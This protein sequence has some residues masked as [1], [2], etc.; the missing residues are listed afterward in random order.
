MQNS[1]RLV[2]IPPNL[3][4]S[5]SYKDLRRALLRV[6][7]DAPAAQLLITA[8][9][10]LIRVE[11]QYLACQHELDLVSCAGIA[12]G[13][14][15]ALVTTLDTLFIFC[16]SEWTESQSNFIFSMNG[17][18]GEKSGTGLLTVALGSDEV[19]RR[20]HVFELFQQLGASAP[21]T[22][23][24]SRALSACLARIKPFVDAELGVIML[25]NGCMMAIGANCCGRIEHSA[26]S[27]T[28]LLLEP[29][30]AD[31]L[32]K[33]LKNWD[34][35]LAKISIDGPL[36]YFSSGATIC[37]ATRSNRERRAE[38]KWFDEASNYAGVRVSGQDFQTSVQ[39][40]SA[41][42]QKD[43]AVELEVDPDGKFLHFTLDCGDGV[44][45]A[46]M[47]TQN[48][49]ELSNKQMHSAR[50]VIS[51]L[52]A[53]ADGYGASSPIDVQFGDKL[54]AFYQRDDTFSTCVLRATR[55]HV[56]R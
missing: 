55:G 21:T 49:A 10:L 54:V 39:R 38:L 11:D 53:L 52:M 25:T 18:S 51:D 42:V 50:L 19:S 7:I 22:S 9:K 33:V 45:R 32:G 35:T 34:G 17:D 44:A 4:F 43:E 31:K 27:S 6:G 23:I 41:Q 12:D 30:S 15:L 47:A 28:E 26:L 3:E 36:V 40:I 20:A 29:R 16:R 24:D 46:T 13:Q 48:G 37:R 56:T 1:E 2:R 8:D 14:S 5:V